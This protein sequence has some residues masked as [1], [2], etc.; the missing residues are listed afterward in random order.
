MADKRFL[1]IELDIK[2]PLNSTIDKELLKLGLKKGKDYLDYTILRKSID[3]RKSVFFFYRIKIIINA[4]SFHKLED[5]KVRFNYH[6]PQEELKIEFNPLLKKC[7]I[8]V[9][10]MGP[11]G[12]I[13]SFVLKKKGFDVVLIDRGKKVEER[14]KDINLFF[15]EK[16][17]NLDSNVQF[18]EGGA[19]TFSD[20]KLHTRIKDKLKTYIY[21]LFVELGAPEEILYLSKPHIGTDKL[22]FMIK[23]FREVLK[24]LGVEIR[25]NTKLEDF[26]IIEKKIE[27][28][29]LKDLISNKIYREVFDFVFLAIGNSSRDTFYML[30]ENGIELQ[31]KPFAVGYRV[32]H[33]QE[34]IDKIQYKKSYKHPKLPPAEYSLTFN[35]KS[36]SVYSFCMCPGGVILNSTNEYNRNVTNGMS[37]YK[38][39]LPFANSAIIV[40]LT[41]EDFK[42]DPFIAIDF[43]RKIEERSFGLTSSYKLPL[44]FLSKFTDKNSKNISEKTLDKIISSNTIPSGFEVIENIED[45]YDIKI[46]ERDFSFINTLIKKAFIKWNS[47]LKN[48]W[49]IG[50]SFITGPETRSSS[51][52]RIVRNK[53]FR[54]VSIEN[55]IPIGEGS[56]YAGGITSSAVDGL[57]A[58]LDL[59]KFL[60]ER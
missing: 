51:P 23:N 21:K 7:R 44:W 18:G 55:L 39:D 45:I 50:E 42:N 13:A 59:I 37:F 58:A 1:E 3:S 2:V 38:R 41:P 4:S 29:I 53:N 11:A 28:I 24:T 14:E 10:G 5:K 8:L 43:Q 48:R 40:S 54:S 19:G 26:E 31:A 22:R 27:G 34:I 12:L 49:I 30:K 36:R 32:L 46:G 17:L 6:T 15:R 9:V 16:V 20:G 25:F 52:I 57:K 35:F 60:E 47:L 56:G 33:P